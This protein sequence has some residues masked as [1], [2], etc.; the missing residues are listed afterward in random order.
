MAT[1]EDVICHDQPRMFA[2][3]PQALQRKVDTT[4]LPQHLQTSV[5]A[6]P[7]QASATST[8]T[9]TSSSNASNKNGKN[10]KRKAST[11]EKGE[12]KEKEKKQKDKEQKQCQYHPSSTTHTTAECRT[13]GKLRTDHSS[14]SAPA[15]VKGR[16]EPS[17]M[18]S[19]P[20]IQTRARQRTPAS[21]QQDL[22][23][24]QCFKCLKYGH[25]ASTCTQPAASIVQPTGTNR[26]AVNSRHTQ[27]Q[28]PQ[29]SFKDEEDA[30]TPTSPATHQ[31]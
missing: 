2:A 17:P 6:N 16:T 29:V 24:V 9:S 8:S 13:K 3:E 26:S 30:T 18:S 25:Y 28:R 4:P 23:K 15:S 20:P 19:A 22:S 1:K 12:E 21:H 5:L 10:N 7:D 31:E 27:V 11:Q 14:E